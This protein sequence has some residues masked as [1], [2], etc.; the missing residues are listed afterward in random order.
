M[1]GAASWEEF[2]SELAPD[3]QKRLDEKRIRR[4][5]GA[6]LADLRKQAGK[7]QAELGS[8]ADIPQ[9]NVSRLENSDDMLL[10]T[11]QRYMQAIGGSAEI[12]L[13]DAEGRA[14]HID[15]TPSRKIA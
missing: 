5:V 8:E 4:L 14:V 9:G 3:A 13:R 11:I 7:S 10:S 6:A 2:R 15:V 12:V 1:K